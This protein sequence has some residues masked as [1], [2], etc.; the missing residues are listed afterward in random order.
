VSDG[1][2]QRLRRWLG[3]PGAGDHQPGMSIEANR[4]AVNT[5]AALAPETPERALPDLAGL[6]RQVAK[7]GREQFKLNT[8]LDA[9]QQQVQSALQ[10]LR[11]Q[12]ER[13]DADHAG[14]LASRQAD[15]SAAR[16]QV[17]E[18]LLPTLDGLDE[19]LAG[20]ERLMAR[21]T[22]SAQKRVVAAQPPDR[23]AHW[24]ATL[25]LPI[26]WLEA[27]ASMLHD[28]TVPGQS[29]TRAQQPVGDSDEWRAAYAGWFR[30]LHLVR[31]RLLETLAVEGVRPIQTAGQPFDPHWHIALDTAPANP[32]APPGTVV[33]EARRGYMTGECVLRYAEVI[34]AHESEASQAPSA[35][36][37]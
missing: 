36:N 13:R 1:L 34:V 24:A 14:L 29:Q 7:L 9:Q 10:Q 23:P 20:G 11:E 22:S 15:L 26:A 5:T 31:E 27:F 3:A 32:D 30:G 16:L 33:A 19:A 37:L 21:M 18:R 28:R 25:A 12:G 6:E 2:R 8:F 17:V 35:D 4:T